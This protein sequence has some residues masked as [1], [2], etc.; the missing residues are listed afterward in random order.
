LSR[1]AAFSRLAESS[2]FSVCGFEARDKILLGNHLQVHSEVTLS[3]S[4]ILHVGD[5]SV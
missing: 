2:Q 1:D 5:S 4:S 3:A